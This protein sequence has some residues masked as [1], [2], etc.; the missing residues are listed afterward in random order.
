MRA[1]PLILIALLALPGAARAADPAELTLGLFAPSLPLGDRQAFADGLGKG[2]TRG[3][4]KKVVAKAYNSFAE[5]AAARP[6]LAV[7][8]GPCVAAQS[9]KN[10]LAV[11]AVGGETAQSWSLFAR[12]GETMT[13]LAGKRLAFARTG[14]RDADLLDNYL[15]GGEVKSA[16]YFGAL[17]GEATAAAAAAAVR[18]GRADAAFAPDAAARG[19]ARLFDAGVVPN[20]AVITLNAGLSLPLQERIRVAILSTPAPGIDGWRASQNA[21]GALA[22]RLGAQPKKAVLAP[23]EPARLADPDLL[24][25]PAKV[26]ERPTLRPLFWVPELP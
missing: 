22:A 16:T 14:C 24:V 2:I 8:D 10:V 19:L 15:F 21:H 11:A 18:E 4:G 23:A 25:L 17:D 9:G 20:A 5:L 1:T 6:D 13:S 26:F 7:L 3:V 12:E